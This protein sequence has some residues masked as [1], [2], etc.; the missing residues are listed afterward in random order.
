MS[1]NKAAAQ[2]ESYDVIV[3]GGGFGGL[4]AGAL[5]G[6]AGRHVLVVDR[7]D[8]PGGNAHAFRR[9][10]YVFDPAIHVTGQAG[11]GLPFDIILRVLGV[12]D[13]VDFTRLDSM[14]GTRFPGLH[15]H[16][17]IGR[18]AF[19]DAHARHFPGERDGLR[20]LLDVAARTTRESQEL[21]P[22]V[23]LRD[24]DKAVARYPTLFKYR[25]LTVSQV[26][27]E[28][29]RDPRAKA[30]VTSSW[31]YLGLPPEELSFFSWSGMLMSMLD[32]GP[33]YSRGSFQRVADALVTALERSGGE[34]V[35][36][37]RVEKILIE[38]GRVAGVRLEGGRTLRAPIVVSNIDARKTYEDLV[39][40]EH[41]PEAF[42]RNLKRLH[43]S[44]SAV[45]VYAGTRLDMGAQP[46]PAHETFLNRHWDHRETQRDI[47]AGRP[48]GMWVNVPS[49]VDPSLAPA[50]EHVVIATSLAPF[51]IGES[52][53]DAKQ[54][55]TDAL[56]SEVDGAFPGFKDAITH[57][58]T[59]TPLTFAH[60]GGTDEGAIYGWANTAAQAGT[61]RPSRTT[62]IPG[63]HL[64][65]HW[66][67]PG[68]GSFRAVWSGM[69]VSSEIQN[70]ETPVTYMDTLVKDAGMAGPPVPPTKSMGMIQMISGIWGSQLIY[71]AAKLGI[72]DLLAEHGPLDAKRLAELTGSHERSLYRVLR[73]LTTLGLFDLNEAGCFRLTP[74]G[75]LL[76]SDVEGSV[77][78]LAI[79]FGEPWHWQSWGN[80]LHS[81]KTGEPAFAHTFGM[82]CYDYVTKHAE[83]A[84]VYDKAMTGITLQAAPGIARHYDFG[85]VRRVMDVGGGHGTLLNVILQAHP[86]LEGMLFDLPHVV[87]GA[88]EPLAAAGLAQRCQVI[89]GSVFNPLPKGADAVMAKSFIHSFDDETSVKLLRNFR[90]ALPEK[91][92]RVLVV[93]MVLPDEQTPHF[94]KLFDIEM[95][96]Q[97]DDGRDRTRA[98]FRALFAKA[99]LELTRVVDTGSPV[100]VIEG[101]PV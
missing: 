7:Q 12:A 77:R 55:Y 43:P 13:L 99:G 83:A 38:G 26:V 30:F 42:V 59:A 82:G 58:E 22:K 17:P 66:T 96:T 65:G 64:T 68:S 41:L 27:D 56:V 32:D 1:S 79:M 4:T 90:D 36:K 89:G 37:T 100:S 19:L 11:R 28:H 45:V 94:G 91:G 18:E 49:L 10:P 52:W 46:H 25:N 5:L 51:A 95:L 75:A 8:G 15:E 9:G 40:T 23:G 2:D 78:Y 34:F 87:A 62:P 16:L 72:P 21:S 85:S 47:L 93:E 57:I 80:L 97:S 20:R 60:F 84:F 76:R 98:E 81:V 39:G 101:V 35:A 70:Y 74:F 54:R 88:H 14:Y 61:K 71:V 31:P 92:G 6:K 33:Y 3:V 73:A 24:L 50:G 29:L 67:Q 44:F 48:G 63:L 86:H 69:L 53:S